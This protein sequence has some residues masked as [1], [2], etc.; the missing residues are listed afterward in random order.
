MGIFV[1]DEHPLMRHAI[2]TLIHR[3]HSGATV[4]EMDQVSAAAQAAQ[5]HGVPSLISM[6]LQLADHAGA[7]GVAELKK[8]FPDAHLMVLSGAAAKDYEELCIEAGADVYLQKSA[9][10]NEVSSVL[11]LFLQES[12]APQI[13]ETPM[14]APTEKLSKRQKQ[15]LV[16]ID[17]GLS[18]RDIAQSLDIS[19]HTV[20]VHLWRMFKRLNVK[21]RSQASHLARTHGLL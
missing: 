17:K 15:L 13:G 2:G 6:D 4:V 21:S 3:I 1:I 12:L 9:G 19:E 16:M 18:N 8:R 10:A 7:Q 5:E 20:K 11:R 14:S